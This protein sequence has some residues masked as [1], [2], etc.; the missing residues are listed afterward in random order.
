MQ[1][2]ILEFKRITGFA[3]GPK[4]KNKEGRIVKVSAKDKDPSELIP[5]VDFV[6][7]RFYANKDGN[8]GATEYENMRRDGFMTGFVQGGAGFDIPE[9]EY[10]KYLDPSDIRD[11]LIRQRYRETGIY[12]GLDGIL[13]TEIPTYNAKLKTVGSVPPHME[14]PWQNNFETKEEYDKAITEYI[15]ENEIVRFYDRDTK[16]PK[17]YYKTEDLLTEVTRKKEST[18]AMLFPEEGW[19]EAGEMGWFGMSTLDMKDLKETEQ[20]KQ[21]EYALTDN[22]IKKYKDTHIGIVV[23]CHI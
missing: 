15:K 20:A 23:D 19:I 22:L 7:S 12:E 18:W 4:I 13:K 8:F 21:D 11:A 10:Y 16:E 5:F 1:K 6:P 2:N 14:E 9:S 3:A 17:E